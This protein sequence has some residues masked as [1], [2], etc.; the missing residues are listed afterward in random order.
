M[1]KV[2][3][4]CCPLPRGFAQTYALEGLKVLCFDTL[5]QVLIPDELGIQSFWC[6]EPDQK[7]ERNIT[8]SKYTIIALSGQEK[9]YAVT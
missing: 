2:Y 6:F 3:L 5:L 7:L 1:P 9:T 4:R 8:R